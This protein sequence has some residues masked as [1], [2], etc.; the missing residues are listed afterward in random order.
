MPPTMTKIYKAACVQAAPEYFD[1]E[2]GVEKTMGLVNE[3]AAGGAKLIAFPECWIP[4]Y[5]WWPWLDSPAAAMK[6]VHPNFETCLTA[7]GPEVQRIARLA[8]E[9]DIYVVLGYSERK[10]GSLYI[11]QLH[12]DPASRTIT[13][14]RKR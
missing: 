8:V 2:A 10:D 13:P 9:R 6:F 5:P 3:A 11:A 4:G 14:R 12:I 1:M 7:D